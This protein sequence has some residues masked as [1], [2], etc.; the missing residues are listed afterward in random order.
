MIEDEGSFWSSA[1]YSYYHLS[2]PTCSLSGELV[3][4][5]LFPK[6]TP[7]CVFASLRV[8]IHSVSHLLCLSTDRMRVSLSLRLKVNDRFLF[9]SGSHGAADN[10]CSDWAV[11]RTRRNL[12]E[13]ARSICLH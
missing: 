13:I 10:G 5:A 12:L 9:Y 7:P 11:T 6:I 1:D 4:T 3:E 8:D 2:P